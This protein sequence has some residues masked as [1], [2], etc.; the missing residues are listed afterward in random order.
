[1]GG[2]N[3]ATDGIFIRQADGTFRHHGAHLPLLITLAVDPRDSSLVYA[4]GLSGV[5]RSQDGGLS[6]R[7]V[8]GW[9]ETEPKGLAIDP[10]SPDTVYA[11]LPDG[12]IVSDDR[13]QTWERRESGLPDR[14]KYTQ[15]V[16][17]D[18]TRGGRVF[19][20]CEKGMFLS[21]NGGRSWRRVLETADT[22]ND[23]QQSPHDPSHWI[24]VSQS[25]GALES[26]DGGLTWKRF[27][28]VPSERALYSVAFDSAEPGRIALSSWTYGVLTSEDDGR[29][30]TDRN[31][32][33]PDPHRV[34]R[35]ASDPDTGALYAS[36]FE[37]ALYASDDFGRTWRIAGLEGSVVRDFTFVPRRK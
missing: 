27:P 29:T 8:T 13:G 1:M 30:W 33:L 9:A 23:I 3:A 21:D 18:R 37:K 5:L 12:F 24:A 14:G 7:I 6:W 17:V 36:V 28:G 32:G 25:A 20:G 35:I 15:S 31:A 16:Q 22:V 19:I 11:A 34:W 2:R 10:A 26:R 4:A